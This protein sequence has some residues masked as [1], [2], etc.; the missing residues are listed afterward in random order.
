MTEQK[1]LEPGYNGQPPEH[2]ILHDRTGRTLPTVI[3]IAWYS[4]PSLVNS[5][6][7]REY[8]SDPG[9][10]IRWPVRLLIPLAFGLLGLQGISEIIKRFAFL[11]GLVPASEFEKRGH[12]T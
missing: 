11:K 3:I 8:S 7:I 12:G 9:G 10:L 4:W 1:S 6:E 2:V 5:F